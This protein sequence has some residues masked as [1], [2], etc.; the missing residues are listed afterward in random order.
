MQLQANL[1]TFKYSYFLKQPKIELNISFNGETNVE[2]AD[3]SRIFQKRCLELKLLRPL[4][5]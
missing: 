5:M 1:V 4:I 2:T 3:T